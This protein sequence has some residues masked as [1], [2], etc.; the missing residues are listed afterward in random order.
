GAYCGCTGGASS[1]SMRILLL[2][3]DFPPARGGIQNL[4]ANLAGG[5]AAAHEVSV[6][7]PGGAGDA[8]WDAG[9]PYSV[10]RAPR[11]SFWPLVMLAFWW[12]ALFRALRRPPHLLVR[13]HARLC[14]ISCAL[15]PL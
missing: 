9:R 15:R 4:L 8:A 10:T 2:T 7:A 12:S 6:A 13:R 1:I 14:P 3:V 5:L 11:A